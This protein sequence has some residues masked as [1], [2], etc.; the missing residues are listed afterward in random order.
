[1]CQIQIYCNFDFPQ[2]ISSV[3]LDQPIILQ[4]F[5]WIVMP[6]KKKLHQAI[7]WIAT[8]AIRHKTTEAFAIFVKCMWIWFLFRRFHAMRQRQFPIHA[9]TASLGACHIGINAKYRDMVSSTWVHH[10]NQSMTKTTKI[11]D[12]HVVDC[13]WWWWCTQLLLHHPK[14]PWKLHCSSSSFRMLWM[15][16]RQPKQNAKRKTNDIQ[17]GSMHCA[18]KSAFVY[19]FEIRSV[20]TTIQLLCVSVWMYQ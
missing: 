1:M 20:Q 7:T 5:N 9:D 15:C 8:I 16:E 6:R 2:I 19:C 18:G 17:F 11:I 3:Q 12:K 13:V 10:Q 4:H 14:Q